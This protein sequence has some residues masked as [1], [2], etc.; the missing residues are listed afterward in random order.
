MRVVTILENTGRSDGFSIDIGDSRAVTWSCFWREHLCIDIHCLAS[1][2]P[3]R[4]L[5]PIDI[6]TLRK[7][8]G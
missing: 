2:L 4:Q 6:I 7:D 8:R 5:L 3:Q 1:F